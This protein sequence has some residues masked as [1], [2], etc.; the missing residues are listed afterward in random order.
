MGLT[1]RRLRPFIKLFKLYCIP[2][3]AAAFFLNLSGCDS[4]LEREKGEEEVQEGQFALVNGQPDP[5][6]PSVG[7]IDG[8]GHCTGTLIGYKTVL[9]A[10][11]CI[12]GASHSFI[13][14]GNT[15]PA[16]KTVVHP[17]YTPSNDW[18]LNRKNDV[19]VLRLSQRVPIAPTPISSRPPSY[20]SELTLAG[21]GETSKGKGD[22]AKRFGTTRVGWVSDNLIGFAGLF[23]MMSTICKGDSGGPS[24]A[25]IGG[26]IV[27]VGI[28]SYYGI[29]CGV[30]GFDQRVDKVIGW[31]LEQAKGDIFYDRLV[32]PP[33][34]EPSQPGQL[35]VII[36][37]PIEGG[38]VFNPVPVVAQVSGNVG[39]VQAE[40]LIN[41]TVIAIWKGPP[42]EFKASLPSGISAIS[43][44]ARDA[45]GHSGEVRINVSLDSGQ[46]KK[47][48]WGCSYVSGG[49]WKEHNSKLPWVL[50]LSFFSYYMAS[51]FWRRV[52]RNY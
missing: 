24:F 35:K 13:I 30:A 48:E 11:H 45:A 2:G 28:H 42:Y 52:K 23:G 41:D 50:F 34:F 9:T 4:T 44:R 12:Q 22:S 32:P 27:Q 17:Q 25:E 15:Y 51:R 43:V 20:F 38:Q 33:P 6:H 19:A 8:P 29:D 7:E 36:L 18:L 26:T 3:V 37:A 39:A 16:Q 10:A 5:G 46:G 47:G 49:S 1:Q 40:L 31:I 21:F 14:Q